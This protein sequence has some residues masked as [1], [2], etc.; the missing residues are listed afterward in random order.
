MVCQLAFSKNL[1]LSLPSWAVIVCT[2][3]F[4]FLGTPIRSVFAYAVSKNPALCRRQGTMQAILSMTSSVAGFTAPSF[5]AGL[6]LRT[7]EQLEDANHNMRVLNGLAFVAPMLSAVTLIALVSVQDKLMYDSGE[8]GNEM[9]ETDSTCLAGIHVATGNQ[10]CVASPRVGA[11]AGEENRH[12]LS[13]TR[14][15]SETKESRSDLSD[16]SGEGLSIPVS[17]IL[18]SMPQRT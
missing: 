11:A 5:I 8:D 18:S 9:D 4:P 6:V 13:R 3:A 2:A 12:L 15:G 7:P 16:S 17:P 1:C 14:T 10:D